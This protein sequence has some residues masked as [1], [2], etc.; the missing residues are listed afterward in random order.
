MSIAILGAG[1]LVTCIALELAD[2]GHR[3]TVFERSA[4][5]LSEASLYNEG[6][7]HLGFVYAADPSFRT[8]ERMLRGAA[9]LWTFSDAGFRTPRCAPCP[10]AHLT[11]LSIATRP[12]E[13]LIVL[14]AEQA[15]ACARIALDHVGDPPDREVVL[16]AALLRVA[17]ICNSRGYATPTEPLE[18]A[19]ATAIFCDALGDA[20][21]LRDVQSVLAHP[22]ARPLRDAIAGNVSPSS[23]APRIRSLT[24]SSAW[25]LP[26]GWSNLQCRPTIAT[27][28]APKQL[29]TRKPVHLSSP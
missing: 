15:V 13:E 9:R 18:I 8:A 4:E 11:T 25:R 14:W 28:H 26:A 21:S 24:G 1:I 27:E 3:L 22:N 2:R 10:H 17:G 12:R 5:P 6:K 29:L 19:A 23:L 7:L 20:S 16:A